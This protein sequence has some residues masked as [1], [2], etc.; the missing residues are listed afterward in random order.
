MALPLI[1]NLESVRARWTSTIVAVL[2]IAGTVGVFVAMLALARGFEATLVASGSAEQRDGPA[3]RRHLARWTARSRSSS[4]ASS[5]TRRASRAAAAGPLVSPE[6]VVVAAL[7]AEEARA[8]TPTC[9]CAACRRRRS[10]VHDQ[11][12]DRRRA[13][14][15][16]RAVRAGRRAATCQRAYAGLALGETVKLRRR[17]A[18]RWWAS[19]DAGGSAFDSELWCDANVLNAGLPA[20]AGH[21]SSRSP[22]GSTSPDALAGVQGRA[23][24]RSAP[25]RAGGARDRL[26]R[27]AVAA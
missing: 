10:A 11:R 7:P 18:G 15:S 13:A 17:H 9:R 6:V 20:P 12:E 21:L 16:A 1:Y 27:E 3:R 2:G 19:F 25:D 22:R 14:S 4:S 26:L 23:R 5:R 8:P 24:R